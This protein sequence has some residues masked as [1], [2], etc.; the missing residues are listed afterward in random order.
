[1]KGFQNTTI[2]FFLA[3]GLLSS[4]AASPAFEALAYLSATMKL[5]KEPLKVS[6]DKPLVLRYAVALWDG[7]VEADQIEQL[8][9]RWSAK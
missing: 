9:R 3:A 1:M 7:R 2:I 4:A 5:H 8:Y 6:S